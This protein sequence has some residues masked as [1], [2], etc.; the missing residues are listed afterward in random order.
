MDNWQL[1]LEGL[2][3][4]KS[5]LAHSY[6]IQGVDEIARQEIG[7]ALSQYILCQN[8][9]QGSESACGQCQSCQL[10]VA[11]THPDLLQIGNKAQAI[12]VDEMRTA[13]SFLEKTAHL[14]GNQVICA[15]FV[16]NMTENAANALLKTLEEPSRGSYLLLFTKNKNALLP[17]IKSRC[18]FLTIKKQS[19]TEIRTEFTG[20]KDYVIGFAQ[21][22][23][24]QVSTWVESE[25]VQ[26]FE[27]VFGM[28]IQWLKSTLPNSALVEVVIEDDE[29]SLFLLYLIQRRIRQLMIKMHDESIVAALT[30]LNH[31]NENL[32]LIK[33]QNRS[34]AYLALLQKLSTLIR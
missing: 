27:T 20:V 31:F 29:L 19:R 15:D 7:A 14:S 22:S 23:S 34:L 3:R 8:V 11:G 6:I 10:F 4:L 25:K 32:V 30:E 28:F 17:T 16:E 33:G 1:R 13:T 18:Q 24:S 26:E 21:E 12:G 5:Q 9:N 2:P